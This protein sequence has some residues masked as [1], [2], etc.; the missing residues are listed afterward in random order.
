MKLWDT[1][2]GSA[3]NCIVYEKHIQYHMITS[4]KQVSLTWWKEL[5][6]YA[7]LRWDKYQ[8]QAGKWLKQLVISKEGVEL[9]L[10]NVEAFTC[11]L[12]FCLFLACTEHPRV[13]RLY[14]VF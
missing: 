10:G 8:G 13:A 9:L 4:C 1:K 6:V 3:E 5:R 14:V 12:P 11:A 7:F 2:S